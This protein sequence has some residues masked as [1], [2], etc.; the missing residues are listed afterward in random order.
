MPENKMQLRSEII[1]LLL[2][3]QDCKN[4]DAKKINQDIEILKKIKNNEYLTKI[5]LNEINE[6]NRDYSN[7]CALFLMQCASE[8]ALERQALDFLNSKKISDNKKFF[9]ISILKQRGV[10]V[11]LDEIDLFDEQVNEFLDNTYNDPE[12]QV[13][14]LDFFENIVPEERLCLILNL[15]EETKNKDKLAIIFS[16]LIHCELDTQGKESEFELVLNA[17]INSNS[18]YSTYGLEHILKKNNFQNFLED[19]TVKKI[20]QAI[21]KN[22]LKQNDFIDLTLTKNSKPDKCLIS[23]VDGKGMFS[24]VF[25]R[26]KKDNTHAAILLTININQG[27]TSVIGF[28]NLSLEEYLK[29]LKRIF[30]NSLCSDINPVALKAIFE[31][32]YNKNFKT[33]TLLPYE[34]AV[35]KKYFNDIRILEYDLSEFL[36]SKLDLVHLT[37]SKVKKIINSKFYENWFY[38]YNENENFDKII[39]FIEKTASEKNEFNIE[40][41]EKKLQEILENDFVQNEEYIK[42]I[43]SEIL[44]QSYVSSLAK[45]CAMANASF[46]LCF[47]KKYLKDFV[48][49]I[50]DRSIFQYYL[51]KQEQFDLKDE[52]ENKNLFEKIRK[53]NLSKNNIKKLLEFYGEKWK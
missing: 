42:T 3:Y 47:N 13:D 24:L 51:K 11:A 37:G 10:G 17:L 8:E 50:L 18:V 6:N 44:I 35:W 22:K 52:N 31:F 5:L 41:I 20:E 2:K 40:K 33:N 4:I 21:K 46:S 1:S 23:L 27:I 48:N 39:D 34:L 28:S 15:I 16:L 49:S 43:N 30:K 14:L 45:F 26:I 7:I 32:Y 19:K 38:L 12:V 25:S 36:N 29:I 53:T 9:I